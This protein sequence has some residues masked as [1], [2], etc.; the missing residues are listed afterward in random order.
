MILRHENG[1][2][3]HYSTGR[4]ADLYREDKNRVKPRRPKKRNR[5]STATGGARMRFVAL[6]LTVGLLV[7]DLGIVSVGTVQA[8]GGDGGGKV[9]VTLV[10]ACQSPQAALAAAGET[11]CRDVFGAGSGQ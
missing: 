1:I 8:H 4:C 9:E 5:N 6:A 10:Q 2:H 3:R 7:G 11:A